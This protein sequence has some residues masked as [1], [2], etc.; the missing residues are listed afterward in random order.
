MFFFTAVNSGLEGSWICTGLWVSFIFWMWVPSEWISYDEIYRLLVRNWLNWNWILLDTQSKNRLSVV[1]GWINIAGW[2]QGYYADLLW[3]LQG[4]CCES[5][6]R[7]ESAWMKLSTRSIFKN[8]WLPIWARALLIRS[9]PWSSS[10]QC[11]TLSP[12]PYVSLLL[13]C[14]DIDAGNLISNQL[15]LV[16]GMF[17]GWRL[18]L[19]KVANHVASRPRSLRFWFKGGG[20]NQFWGRCLSGFLRVWCSWPQL[21]GIRS[22]SKQVGRDSWS[23]IFLYRQNGYSFTK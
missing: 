13:W 16:T 1:E 7:C 10:T 17:L 18:G 22:W 21:C 6:L 14:F 9:C 20:W 8:T 23:W 15:I 12:F 11:E 5:L 19:N 3:C 4:V 2:L